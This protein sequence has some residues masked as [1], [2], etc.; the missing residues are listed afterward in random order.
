MTG[1][2]VTGGDLKKRALELAEEAGVNQATFT[3]T[4]LWWVAL[5]KHQ[6]DD[7]R[8]VAPL[9]EAKGAEPENLPSP[10]EMG[11]M[12]AAYL[13][14]AKRLNL[15][16]RDI[17]TRAD[18]DPTTSYNLFESTMPRP[19]VYQ[20]LQR[21]MQE[22]LEGMRGVTRQFKSSKGI[23]G[24]ALTAIRDVLGLSQTEMAPVLGYDGTG[25]KSIVSAIETGIT[26]LQPERTTLLP[27]MLRARLAEAEEPALWKDVFAFLPQGG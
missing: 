22:R 20:S 11:R 25:G 23:D 26:E 8:L 2:T 3:L 18:I 21:M 19:A 4:F 15:G 1:T 7:P 13:E 10:A 9:M 24:Q 6:I 17:A 5:H 27:E 16:M 14:L 12:R